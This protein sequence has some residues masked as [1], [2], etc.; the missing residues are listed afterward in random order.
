MQIATKGP[1]SG[2]GAGTLTGDGGRSSTAIRPSSAS[3]RLPSSSASTQNQ[4]ALGARRSGLE[5]HEAPEA[6]AKAAQLGIL[7]RAGIGFEISS[8]P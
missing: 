4:L 1:S 7:G 5:P 6:A 2:A 3:T 8:V